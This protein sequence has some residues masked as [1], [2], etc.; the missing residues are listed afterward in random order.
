MNTVFFFCLFFFCFF[1]GGDQKLY[2]VFPLGAGIY[3]SSAHKALMNNSLIKA[4]STQR[5]GEFSC[6]SGSKQGGIGHF[7]GRDGRDIAYKSGDPFHVSI[8]GKRNPGLIQVSS[9]TTLYASYQGVYTCRIPDETGNFVDIN[10]GLYRYEFNSESLIIQLV[11]DRSISCIQRICDHT[12]LSPP[13][14][15]RVTTLERSI[16]S[17][18][19]TLTCTSTGSPPTT[20]TWTKDGVTLPANETIYSFT[21][22]LVDRATSTY[23]NT[24]TI[25][26]SFVDVIGNYSCSVSNSIGTSSVQETKIKGTNCN[27]QYRRSGNFHCKNIFVVCV[28]CVNHKNK[29]MKYI[30][31]RMII[32]VSKFRVRLFFVS[33]RIKLSIV[34]SRETTL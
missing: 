18:F 7:F 20:V 15:P 6:M 3:A 12:F 34:I 11:T 31:Q 5:L 28:S 16:S 13:A 17:S 1:L 8:G 26:A 29:S 22:T 14:A 2:V 21:Q 32:T 33:Q 27:L 4:D 23:N 24:L 19:T 30:L 9:Y 25:D 10:V